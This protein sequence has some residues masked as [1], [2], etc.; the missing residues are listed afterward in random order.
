MADA[1]KKAEKAENLP[2]DTV[3]DNQDKI[4]KVTDKY[5]KMIDASVSE[6][7]KEVMTV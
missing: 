4:Q 7:E 3:K 6:K 5:T 2:E 1:L